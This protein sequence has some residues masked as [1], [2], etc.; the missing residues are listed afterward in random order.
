MTAIEFQYKLIN[1]QE[2][3]MKFAYSLTANRDDAKDLV[4]DTCLKALKYCD[5]FKH[6]SNFKGWLFTIMKNSFINSYRR[7]I[8]Q[9]THRDQTKEG[10]YLN[11]VHASDSNNPESV[12]SSKELEKIIEGLSNDFKIPFKMYHDGF[13][14]KEIAKTLDLKIGTVK[15]RIF[16]TKKK[17]IYQLMGKRNADKIT[18]QP[19]MN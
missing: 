17:L 13:K 9:N 19:C 11:S 7:R 4:Q 1:L 6:E 15:S 2:T 8:H 14:Y 16:F 5:K 18:F 3:L 12:Y 10:Y